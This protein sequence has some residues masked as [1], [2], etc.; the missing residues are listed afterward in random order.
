[1]ATQPTNLPVPSESPR[2]LKFNAGKIDEFVSSM[3]RE[4]EDRFGNKHYTIEGL[5]W[6]AQQAIANFGY[7]TLDS[8]EDG[9][10]LTL[11][12]QVLRYEST[13]E[14][15]RWDGPLPKTVPAGSTPETTG[16]VG[17]GAWLSVG[18]AS[19]RADL[20]S[21][22][23]AYLIGFGE[24]HTVA[25]ISSWGEGNGDSLIAVKQPA[26]GAVER[27]QHNKN[28]EILSGD[29]FGIVSDG[30]STTP[31]DNSVALQ[32]ALDASYVLNKDLH[33]S[34]DIYFTGT[35]KCRRPFLSNGRLRF[36][37]GGVSGDEFSSEIQML[38]GGVICNAGLFNI[39][40]SYFPTVSE[41]DKVEDKNGVWF[42]GNYGYNVGVYVGNDTSTVRFVRI[43]NNNFYIAESRAYPFLTLTNCSNVH[44]DNNSLQDYQYFVFG[45]A[46]RSYVNS[47]WNIRHNQA[48]GSASVLSMMGSSM[49]WFSGVHV[50]NN[51]FSIQPRTLSTPGSNAI[52]LD[53]VSGLS[54]NDNNITSSGGVY[55]IRYSRDV[56]LKNNRFTMNTNMGSMA[57]ILK[58]DNLNVEGD[59]YISTGNSNYLINISAD[60]NT[61][62][63]V[64]TFVSFK[65]CLFKAPERALIFSNYQK[66][67]VEGNL[68]QR[69]SSLLSSMIQ[70]NNTCLFGRVTNND[71]FVPSGVTPISNSAASAATSGGTV[72]NTYSPASITVISN[73][74]ADPD[75]N[76]S[77]SYIFTFTLSDINQLHGYV[78]DTRMT[79][80]NFVASQAASAKLAWNGGFYNSNDN[81]RT[82]DAICDG[83]L[84]EFP[85]RENYWIPCTFAINKE[86]KLLNRDFMCMGDNTKGSSGTV[87]RSPVRN[88]AQAMI[89]EGII[90]SQT[91][92]PPLI[93]SGIIYNASIT[94][95][96]SDINTDTSVSARSAIGQKQDGTWILIVVD[97]T[98]GSQGCTL[99]QLANKMKSLGAHH[100]CNLDGGGSASVWYNGSVINN[101]SDGTERHIGSFMWV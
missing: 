59:T 53:Y 60:A 21:T 94:E 26:S 36:Y 32:Q 70:I 80:S 11:P 2:D 90:N 20:A 79:I 100:A 44:I 55:R 31:T 50:S 66:V 25:D 14:Y 49:N 69:N 39:K 98:S 7:I 41:D 45:N 78:S 86:G 38:R 34:G 68:F 40:V 99:L 72:N 1:M 81:Y 23:G 6:I 15:Y 74:I 93:S 101:P 73:G 4:Y 42:Y 92:R 62:T 87:A 84:V 37:G 71:F 76:N 13:G 61:G 88:I 47:N 96:Y 5:R 9:N 77:K 57:S 82:G 48:T 85:G 24:G 12:N 95:L 65:N 52:Y 10:T 28:A 75:L 8:F 56:N 16:G 89:N 3:Q 67:V 46:T 17:T 30:A 64:G 22:E 51:T 54:I 29:D 58:V 83:T 43:Y 97:G 91:T 18:D 33:L 35:V 19:F 27:S 63:Q